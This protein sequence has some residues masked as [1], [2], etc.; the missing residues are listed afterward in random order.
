[1]NT[2]HS[3]INEMESYIPFFQKKEE[4]VS[5]STIGWQLEHT[6]LTI[7]A[8]IAKVESSNPG[9]FRWSFKLPRYIV[10]TL[11]KI[12]RGRA[13]SPK[14]VQPGNDISESGLLQHLTSARQQLERFKQ[15]HEGNFFEHPI[16]GHLKTKQAIRFL[17][18]H[19][20][21]HLEIVKD[22]IKA[23]VK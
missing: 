20:K 22:I 15:M 2:L 16:F 3:L 7:H 1:M 4:R 23:D 12:P 5:A 9:D 8:I 21:H 14:H 13:Q 6:L 19:T 17:E 18:I 10:F 11:G